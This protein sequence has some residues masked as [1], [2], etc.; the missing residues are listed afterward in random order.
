MVLESNKKTR[1][2]SRQTINIAIGVPIVFVLPKVVEVVPKDEI[3]EKLPFEHKSEEINIQKSD[4]LI[5]LET[6][7]ELN[8]D[9]FCLVNNENLEGG[10]HGYNDSMYQHLK[11]TCEMFECNNMHSTINSSQNTKEEESGLMNMIPT[12]SYFIKDLDILDSKRQGLNEAFYIAEIGELFKK[13]KNFKTLLPRVQPFY[14]V[15][16]NNNKVMLKTLEFLGTNFDCASAEE[17]RQVLA[18]GISPERIIYANPCKMEEHISFAYENNVNCMTFDNVD[19]LVKIKENHHNSSL[20]LRI[21]VD[22]SMSSC[23]F[24]LK[25][26]VSSGDTKA[27]LLKAHELGTNIVGVSFH[28]GSGCGDPNAY[29]YALKQARE[30]FDEANE[31]GFNMQIIDI[32]G[33]FPGHE[34]KGAIKFEK[35]ADAINEGLSKYFS[36]PEIKI[37][38]EPGRYFSSSF[39]SLVTTIT[40]KREVLKSDGTKSFMYYINDGVYG[41]FNCLIF[42]HMELPS[43]MYG[44]YDESSKKFT[45]SDREKL[46]PLYKCSIWGPTCDS[47]DVLSKSVDYP[48][49]KIGDRLFFSNMGA[50]TLAAATCFNGFA[51]PKVF[52]HYSNVNFESKEQ[53]K[54]FFIRMNQEE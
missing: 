27:L 48:E 23:P 5:E 12:N 9:S 53:Q 24:G 31:I 2:S 10:K 20:L 49:L 30:V 17:I 8:K 37:I 22:D 3:L 19:E 6:F 21:R 52:Y 32:G 33:G 46:A 43:P 44:I 35:F 38:A 54:R 11:T 1:N 14:A 29:L 41:S 7:A 36:S 42:D 47:M 50:Y 51:P 15:K 16:S 13:F 45:F 39:F 26:G 25:F 34:A 4:L 28:V 18:M 40:S